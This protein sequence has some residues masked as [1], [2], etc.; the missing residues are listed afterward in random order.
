MNRIE[1]HRALDRLMNR[2][3]DVESAMRLLVEQYNRRFP[4]ESLSL[5]LIHDRKTG[6]CYGP[7]WGKLRKIKVGTNGGTRRI[8]AKRH[9]GTRLTRKQMYLCGMVRHRA[10]LRE[11]DGRARKLRTAHNREAGRLGKIRQILRGVQE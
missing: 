11:Y 4:F 10:E 1:L 9:Y 2:V 7:Y 8:T 5:Y 6:Q 3:G